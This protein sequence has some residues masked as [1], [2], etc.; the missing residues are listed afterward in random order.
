VLTEGGA[1]VWAICHACDRRAGR[2]LRAGWLHVAGWL[3]L[4]ILAIVVAIVLLYWFFGPS[5]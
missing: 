4:P 5:P 1:H 3:M 2:S